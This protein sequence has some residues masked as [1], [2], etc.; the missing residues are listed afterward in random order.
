[1]ALAVAPAPSTS[2]AGEGS[3]CLTLVAHAPMGMQHGSGRME[4]VV[5]PPPVSHVVF[6]PGDN[7]RN[8]MFSHNC[9]FKNRVPAS[10]KKKAGT[11]T[12]YLPVRSSPVINQAGR[13]SVSKSLHSD[14]VTRTHGFSLR[15]AVR[16]YLCQWRDLRK[17]LPS[18][19][20]GHARRQSLSMWAR[21]GQQGI[22]YVSAARRLS[23]S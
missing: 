17:S 1:M 10:I 11:E 22:V 9:D 7:Q 2:R 13:S 6:A 20:F 23:G 14:V 12:S 16:S 5:V 3:G 21:G 15:V 4:V 19:V 18:T 8:R